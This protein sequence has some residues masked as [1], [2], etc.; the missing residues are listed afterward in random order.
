VLTLCEQAAGE[1]EA[2]KLVTS[3]AQPEPTHGSSD[4]GAR[5][6]PAP[7][8]RARLQGMTPEQIVEARRRGD[9]DA[10]LNGETE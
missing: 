2:Q 1:P 3:R 5:G 10:L 7:R 8:G 9:L 4:H 6:T